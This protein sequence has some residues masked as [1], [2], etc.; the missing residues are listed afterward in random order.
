M[1]SGHRNKPT[2]SLEEREKQMLELLSVLTIPE[3]KSTTTA[4][5]RIYEKITVQKSGKVIGIRSWSI[6][7][8]A[9]LFL[10]LSFYFLLRQAPN[11]TVIANKGKNVT[12]YLPD[13]SMV[14][15]NAESKIT[16]N[17][18]NWAENRQLELEG[19]AF[20][21]VRKGEKFQVKS[22]EGIVEVLGT[23]FNVFA[24]NDQYNVACMTGKVKVSN[25]QLDDF[26]ILN[27]GF[28][29]SIKNNQVQEVVAFKEGRNTRWLTGEFH[30]EKAPLSTV[31]EEIERQYDINISSSDSIGQRL[32]SGYFPKS[33]LAATLDLV[34]SPMGLTF[35]HIDGNNVVITEIK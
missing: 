31:I 3:G 22:N 2:R 25:S 33:D 28:T 26:K 34:F 6:G 24:R 35:Q 16:Y 17:A 7:I 11:T 12:F 10:M 19:E 27:P 29:T 15:M 18:S 9:S 5:E 8:A 1:E 32:Y 4:W 30:F 21:K 13:S 14:I 23:S 20:F